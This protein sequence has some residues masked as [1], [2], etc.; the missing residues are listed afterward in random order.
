MKSYEIYHCNNMITNKYL[1]SVL[2]DEV[3]YADYKLS[4]YNLIYSLGD[5]RYTKL[6]IVRPKITIRQLDL[7]LRQDYIE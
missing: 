2:I 5:Y 4:R 7:I 3:I 6:F 1:I